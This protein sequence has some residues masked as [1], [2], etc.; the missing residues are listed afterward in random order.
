MDQTTNLVADTICRTVELGVTITGAAVA[1]HLT[2]IDCR[3]VEHD[4]TCPTCGQPGRLRDH[5][6]R[7]LPVVA[8]PPAKSSNDSPATRHP[9]RRRLQRWG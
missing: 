5:V 2:H 6:T 4:P 9:F 7:T 8:A 1:E 3:P